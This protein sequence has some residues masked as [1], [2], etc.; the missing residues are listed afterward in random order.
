MEWI[1]VEKYLPGN[2][3]DWVIVRCVN[4]DKE[5]FYFMAIYHKGWEYFDDGQEYEKS[6]RITHWCIPDEVVTI[7]D[8]HFVDGESR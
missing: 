3:F 1:N 7:R 8:V 6:M 4:P 5:V 2:K